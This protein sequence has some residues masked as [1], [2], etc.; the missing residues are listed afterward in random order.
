MDDDTKSLIGASLRTLLVGMP[1]IPAGPNPFAMVAQAWSEY[2]GHK[3]K[4]RV[5]E[6]IT[7]IHARLTSIE[8]LQENHLERLLDIEDQVA[9][10]EETV[11]ATSREPNEG[12]RK[13]FADFY[14]AAVTG[15]LGSDPDPIRSMLQTLESLTPSDI[16]LLKRFNNAS[17][18]CAGDQL[19]G[20]VRVDQWERVGGDPQA[21]NAW[22]VTLDPIIQKVT[23][24]ETRG[25][26]IETRRPSAFA[27]S[28]D[29]GNWYNIFRRKAWRITDSGCQLLD[30]VTDNQSAS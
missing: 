19:S 10:L 20:T 11:S 25:L 9:L 23:K 1:S 3:F 27:H 7:A 28:G 24:L 14:V 26:I 22:S 13:A 8:S 16:E 4:K 29:A 5:E 2:E 30:A 6:F 12:K 21:E 17:G 18:T 15:N